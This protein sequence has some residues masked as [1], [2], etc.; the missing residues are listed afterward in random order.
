MSDNNFFKCITN[1]LG[2]EVDISWSFPKYDSQ[3]SQNLQD[4]FADS[5]IKIINNSTKI[6]FGVFIQHIDELKSFLGSRLDL[7]DVTEISSELKQKLNNIP[8]YK[9]VTEHSIEISDDQI[10]EKLAENNWSTERK[11]KWYQMRNLKKILKFSAAAEFSVPGA[12]KTTTALAFYLLKRKSENSKLL[13]ISPINAFS[14]WDEELP[15][16]LGSEKKMTRLR[17]KDIR[18]LEKELRGKNQFFIT[19]YEKIR[20]DLSFLK[21]LTE[22]LTDPNNDYVLILDESHKM[23]G[24]QTAKYIHYLSHLINKKLILTGTPMP[25]NE[26]DLFPQFIH[27]YPRENIFDNSILREKFKPIFARTTKTDI[28]LPEPNEVL[29]RIPLEGAQRDCYNLIVDSIL[30]KSYDFEIKEDLRAFKKNVMRMLMFCSNPLLQI[31]YLES[32][33]SNLALSLESEGHGSKMER[34]ISDARKLLN[35]NENEKLVIWS[36][37]PTN[38]ERLKNHL[39]E[40]DP[41]TIHGGVGAGTINSPDTREYNINKFKNV[42]GCRVFIANPGAAAEGISLHKVCR[43]AF[44]L[45]RNYNAAHYLQSKDRIHRIGSDPEIPVNIFIYQL[46]NTIDFQVH[47]NLINKIN[48]MSKFLNDPSIISNPKVLDNNIYDVDYSPE[49]V[50]IAENPASDKKTYIEKN[51][52]EDI[53]KFLKDNR[54]TKKDEN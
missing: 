33:D 44:Y 36:G 1:S 54:N 37:F 20:S 9:N 39:S 51:D 52:M 17:D 16:C 49:S 7:Y 38:I 21:L 12:G 30:K 41:V 47:T 32:I 3:I 22:E 40:F 24:T 18:I 15:E 2:S 29:L 23:K 53:L 8:R 50:S 11:L 26:D 28:N 13:V 25:L 48:E 42:K 6:L 35:E 5:K 45:D 4:I 43:N 34:V 14:A 31:H 46:S 19:N 10:L 27:L